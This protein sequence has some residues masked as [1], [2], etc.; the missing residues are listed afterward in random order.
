MSTAAFRKLQM[1]IELPGLLNDLDY[2]M[3]A[4]WLNHVNVDNYQGQWR[5]FP[6]RCAVEHQNAHPILQAF[7][8]EGVSV[9]QDMPILEHCPAIR[10]VLA[11]IN[12]PIK[13]VRLMRLNAGAKIA[14]HN[15]AGLAAEFGEARLHIPLITSDKVRFIVAGQTVPMRAGE[16]WYIN[17][18]ETHCVANL[19]NIDRINLVI[20]C[21]VNDWL[22]GQLHGETLA[23]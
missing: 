11:N 4:H 13:A 18:D 14:A 8:I 16:L 3:E 9:W 7:S 12:C 19:S 10:T 17:A 6:L 15:D 23:S 1:D 2:L 5:I 21:E 22:M 20:D